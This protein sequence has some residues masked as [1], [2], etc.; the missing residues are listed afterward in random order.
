MDFSFS[1]AK[2]KL[3]RFGIFLIVFDSFPF[4]IGGSTYRPVSIFPL[5]LYFCLY[6]YENLLRL[7][8]KKV[9]TRLLGWFTYLFAVSFVKSVDYGTFD[10]IKDFFFTGAIGVACFISLYDFFSIQKKNYNESEFFEFVGGLFRRSMIIPCVYGVL[11]VLRFYVHIPIP[12]FKKIIGLATY[13]SGESRVFLVCGEPAWAA[14]YLIIYMLFI[15]FCDNVKFKKAQLL[16]AFGLTMLTLSMYAYLS[17]VIAI[18]LYFFFLIIKKPIILPKL[19]I[20][21]CFGVIIFL[22]MDKYMST[23]PTRNYAITRYLQMRELALM[24]TDPT[25]LYTTIQILDG[26]I[27]IRFI[28]PLIGIMMSVRDPLF[29]VGGGYFY[30]YYPEY[31]TKYFPLAIKF[32]EVKAA[33]SGLIQMSPRNLFSKFYAEYGLVVGTYILGRCI[34]LVNRIDKNNKKYLWLLSVI[35]MSVLNFDSLCYVVFIFLLTFFLVITRKEDDNTVRFVES[36]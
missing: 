27:F 20:I 16:L 18:I 31:I 36:L 17:I 30:I 14:T 35:F 11:E 33:V 12:M 21:L 26:S 25:L 15:I 6:S 19:I 29:G 32:N 24:A 10:G 4:F 22:A 5:L 2:D 9:D 34:A 8:I 23:T 7:R 28:T 13:R 1:N 3:A